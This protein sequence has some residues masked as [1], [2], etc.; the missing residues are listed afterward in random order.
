[1]IKEG[2]DEKPETA[3]HSELIFFLLWEGLTRV[4][5]LPLVGAKTSHQEKANGDNDV[6]SYYIGPH[7][8][9]NVSFLL[10]KRAY[11]IKQPGRE[12]GAL[13]ETLFQI[14]TSYVKIHKS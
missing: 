10:R 13:S 12:H 8:L 11:I 14:L 6:G 3:E 2:S 4:R 7:L 9:E 5:I 1:M